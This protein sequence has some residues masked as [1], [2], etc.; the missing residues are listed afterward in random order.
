[1]KASKVRDAKK[2]HRRWAIGFLATSL[3]VLAFVAISGVTSFGL[4]LVV[5][6]LGLAAIISFVLS[7]FE[8][9]PDSYDL[10]RSMGQMGHGFARGLHMKDPHENADGSVSPQQNN[11]IDRDRSY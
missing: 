9:Q 8:L 2:H 7:F 3:S 6:F 11:D 1:M 10:T 4:L 5:A